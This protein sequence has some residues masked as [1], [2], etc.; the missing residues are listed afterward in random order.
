MPINTFLCRI[1]SALYIYNNTSTETCYVNEACRAIIK[2]GCTKG[3]R[4][5]RQCVKHVNLPG[6]MPCKCD[7]CREDERTA[8]HSMGTGHHYDISKRIFNVVLSVL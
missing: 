6:T 1:S 2:L 5:K 3:C 4:G 7:G 8:V